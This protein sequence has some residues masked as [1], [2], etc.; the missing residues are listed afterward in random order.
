MS[1]GSL[2]VTRIALV[3]A[4]TRNRVIGRDNDMPWHLPADLRHFRALTLGHPILMGRR[5]HLAI[6]RPLPGR[7]NLVLSRQ[8]DL[9]LPGVERVGS[10][11]EALARCAGEP[12]LYVVGGA[13]VYRL[14][15][16]R[17]ERLHLTEIDA[18]LEG[19]AWFPQI[20]AADWQETARGRHLADSDN[21]FDL[22]FRTLDRRR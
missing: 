13:E 21:R 2:P 6:G 19:D 9:A 11:D 3:V 14:A 8:A 5:T 22:H 15:L 16:P 17:A 20:D 18:E 1:G 12:W 10:L 7:R 4:H